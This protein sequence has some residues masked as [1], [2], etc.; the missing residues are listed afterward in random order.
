MQAAGE[1]VAQKKKHDAPTM[2][3]KQEEHI[4]AAAPSAGKGK[5]PSS[6]LDETWE[7]EYKFSNN[8]PSRS[9]DEPFTI[10]KFFQ[11]IWMLF[12]PGRRSRRY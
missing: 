7:Y 10:V 4:Q 2:P 8:L 3:E 6:Y 5:N 9:Q 1:K 11:K 12:F